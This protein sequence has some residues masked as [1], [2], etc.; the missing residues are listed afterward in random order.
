MNTLKELFQEQLKDL[1]NAEKQLVKALPAMAR[2]AS[3]PSLKEAFTSHLEETDNH[4]Q[5]LEQIG[6]A[7]D[8]NLKGKVC[9]A[10]QGLIEE[11]KEVLKEK[12]GSLVIDAALIAAARAVEHYEMSA[13]ESALAVAQQLGHKGAV[14]LLEATLEEESAAD[15]KLDAISLDQVLPEAPLAA[16]DT[17]TGDEGTAEP[18]RKGG[19]KGR[20]GR[21]A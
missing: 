14:E 18:A 15:E 5:R 1:H 6:E 13:Y 4:V 16:E 19:N 21:S 3:T 17:D 7:L 12:G 20:A 10:M 8:L 9:K 2:K 11:G